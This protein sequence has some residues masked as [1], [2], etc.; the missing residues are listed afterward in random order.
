M[1][2]SR[3]TIS[4]VISAY[5][6][7]R[8]L[9]ECLRSVSWAD[10]IVVVNNSSTDETA[11]I[12][13]KH[14]AVVITQP[15]HVMLNTNK[16]IGFKKATGNWILNLDADERV[17]PK[18]KKEID[19]IV[20]R[21]VSGYYIPRKNIIFGKWMQHTGWYPDYQLRLFKKGAG[22][23]AEKHIH[24]MIVVAGDTHHLSEPMI[25]ENYQTIAQFI[26]KLN[27]YTDNEADQIAKKGYIFSPLDAIIY[28][29]EEFFRR[30]FAGEGYKDGFHGLL[31]SMTMA[32]YHFV[33][34]LK[35]WEKQ[36]FVQSQ[37]SSKDISSEVTKTYLEYMQWMKQAGRMRLSFLKRLLI[38][39]SSRL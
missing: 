29:K 4:I 19:I 33:I 5:N 9:P 24:E 3:E 25:H 17:T 38:S 2:H 12:A 18:L 16:N 23:F 11:A 28:P 39:L 34:F 21:E 1:K 27:R 35:L 26:E 22:K 20:K 36:R 31:L 32:W 14:G 30:Y 37:V 10:E 15:N 7:A 13:K 6:E 8:M